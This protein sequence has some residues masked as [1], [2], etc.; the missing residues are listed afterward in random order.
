MPTMMQDI[1]PTPAPGASIEGPDV[2]N[3]NLQFLIWHAYG[4]SANLSNFSTINFNITNDKGEIVGQKAGVV[5][6]KGDKDSKV[7]VSATVEKGQNVLEALG[8]KV[9]KIIEK[10]MSELEEEKPLFDL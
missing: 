8:K 9:N 1:H 6:H 10:L 5:M 2:L 7:L 3:R 4:P